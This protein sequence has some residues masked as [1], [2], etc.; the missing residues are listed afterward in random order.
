MTDADLPDGLVIGDW[1]DMP[2][3]GA[4]LIVSEAQ[5]KFLWATPQICPGNMS[6]WVLGNDGD[7]YAVMPRGRDGL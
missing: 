6:W 2:G 4:Y 3:E 1:K 5:A 7:E